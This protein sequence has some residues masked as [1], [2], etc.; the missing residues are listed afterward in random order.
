MNKKRFT[1][2]QEIGAITGVSG[3][4][5]MSFGASQGNVFP[6]ILGIV[7][8]IIGGWLIGWSK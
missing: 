6:L 7:L 2:I 1:Q 3:F 5:L 8:I 4:I